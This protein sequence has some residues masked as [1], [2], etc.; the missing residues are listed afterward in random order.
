MGS[1]IPRRPAANFSRGTSGWLLG[2]SRN[3]SPGSEQL[4]TTGAMPKNVQRNEKVKTSRTRAFWGM[5]IRFSAASE[6]Y[7]VQDNTVKRIPKLKIHK[8]VLRSC[9][10]TGDGASKSKA[11]KAVVGQSEF[12]AFHFVVS[13]RFGQRGSGVSTNPEP[14]LY[15]EPKFSSRRTLGA[16]EVSSRK[17]LGE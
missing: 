9:D 13:L 2:L 15:H 5:A 1:T 16:A 8:K 11:R 10:T 17:A 7:R 14:H 3:G 4:C 6:N 12:P